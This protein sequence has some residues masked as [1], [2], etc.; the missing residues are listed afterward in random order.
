[1]TRGNVWGT[2]AE[3]EAI[4]DLMDWVSRDLDRILTEHEPGAL[5][6]AIDRQI[7]EILASFGAA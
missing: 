4:D 7:D 2:T 5:P 1:M 3:Q 6:E